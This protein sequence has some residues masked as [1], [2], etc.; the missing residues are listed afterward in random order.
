MLQS[1][2][3]YKVPFPPKFPF[4]I[5]DC[6]QSTTDLSALFGRLYNTIEAGEST[7]NIIGAISNIV[8]KV[9]PLLRTCGES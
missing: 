9:E 4:N 1:S 2:E 3:S 8:V 5:T 7:N 6:L